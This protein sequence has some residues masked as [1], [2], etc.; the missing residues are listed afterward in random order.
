MQMPLSYEV[1]DFVVRA[2]RSPKVATDKAELERLQRIARKD[3]TGYFGALH[4]PIAPLRWQARL[5]LNGTDAKSNRQPLQMPR[6]MVITAMYLS[7]RGIPNSNPA[8]AVPTLDDIDLKIDINQKTGLTSNQGVTTAATPNEQDGNFVVANSWSVQLPSLIELKLR[9]PSPV[10]GFQIQW[11]RGP[12]AA[13]SQFF[14]DAIFSAVIFARDYDSQI[15]SNV[16]SE[17][18]GV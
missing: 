7:I 9:N 5:R 3:H 4:A 18:E 13:G 8:A 2:L 10:L 12:G 6:K 17:A 15:S 11:I 16:G 14:Q 1:S